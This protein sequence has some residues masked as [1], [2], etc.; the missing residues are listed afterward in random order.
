MDPGRGP[1]GLGPP[2]FLTKLKKIVFET[3]LPSPLISVS[4]SATVSN[5]IKCGFRF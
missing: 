5:I 4:K 1:G 2:Y 3:T